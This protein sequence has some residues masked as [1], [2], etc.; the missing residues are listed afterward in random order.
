[1]VVGEQRQV[2]IG[3]GLVC[4]HQRA[5]VPERAVRGQRGHLYRAA[6]VV[7]VGHGQIATR[8]AQH[9]H[10]ATHQHHTGFAFDQDD[11]AGN[12]GRLVDRGDVHGD[13]LQGEQAARA[14]VHRDLKRVGGGAWH[15]VAVVLVAE[16]ADV[17]HSKG[18]AD[19]HLVAVELEHALQRQGGDLD[20][21][22][23]WRVV[24][25]GQTQVD[26]LRWA[27]GHSRAGGNGE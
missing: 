8:T 12:G 20:D 2:G 27:A 21:D 26:L 11:V 5:V 4:G 1:M 14:I 22:L 18:G 24:E 6:V 13:S 3:D 17:A 15:L 23:V 25:I 10:G 16:V 19:R 7:R 9:R